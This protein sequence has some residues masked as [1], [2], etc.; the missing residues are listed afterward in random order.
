MQVLDLIRDLSKRHNEIQEMLIKT[1]RAVY[2]QVSVDTEAVN[3]ALYTAGEN[4][5]LCG[6]ADQ[7]IATLLLGG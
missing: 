2:T 3:R 1:Q 5:K 6:H 7:V 4:P